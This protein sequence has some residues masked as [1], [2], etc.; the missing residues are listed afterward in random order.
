MDAWSA[1]K[2]AY[3]FAR[4]SVQLGRVDKSIDAGIAN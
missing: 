2:Y 1:G 3:Q 4:A